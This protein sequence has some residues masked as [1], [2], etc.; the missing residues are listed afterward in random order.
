[1]SML[2]RVNSLFLL[3][4]GPQ[5]QPFG[6][7]KQHSEELSLARVGDRIRLSGVSL[8]WKKGYEILHNDFKSHGVWVFIASWNHYWPWICAPNTP[9][10]TIGYPFSIV[11][12]CYRFQSI[13]LKSD[14]QILIYPSLND[15]KDFDF[16]ERK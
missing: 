11:S 5:Q 15:K 9:N 2:L 16:E 1:M 7:Q 6:G 12:L 10:T 4:N 3:R 14:I 8:T 13:C